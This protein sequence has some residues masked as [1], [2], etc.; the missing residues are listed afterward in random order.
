MFTAKLIIKMSLSSFSWNFHNFDRTVP[1]NYYL[2]YCPSKQEPA[3]W[4]E[5]MLW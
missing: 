3:Q 2:H 1:D 4:L 5:L